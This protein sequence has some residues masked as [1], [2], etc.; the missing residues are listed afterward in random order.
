MNHHGHVVIIGFGNRGQARLPQLR[1][2]LPDHTVT[3]VEQHNDETRL[4][5]A[6][7]WGARL[8]VRR[9]DA[10]NH[11]DALGSLL[12]KGEFPLNLTPEGCVY[13]PS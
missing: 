12:G 1:A 11:E 6:S 5:L 10:S 2:K 4:A 9:A 13:V 7:A 8:I 3:A